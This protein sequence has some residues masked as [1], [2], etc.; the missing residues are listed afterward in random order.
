MSSRIRNRFQKKYRVRCLMCDKMFDSVSKYIRTCPKCQ[1]ARKRR[2]PI[3]FDRY[4]IPSN[5][6]QKNLYK[7]EVENYRNFLQDLNIRD[8]Y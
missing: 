5:V 1:D 7:V 4:N 2:V 3:D 6:A 8:T